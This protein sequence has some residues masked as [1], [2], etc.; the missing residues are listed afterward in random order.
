MRFQPWLG[1]IFVM[2]IIVALALLGR[3]EGWIQSPTSQ[4]IVTV[5]GDTIPAAVPP[6]VAAFL[7]EGRSWRAARLMRNVLARAMQPSA[8]MVLLAARAE[9]G[10][11]GWDRVIAYLEG[12]SWLDEVDGGEG[13][14]WLARALDE[15]GRPAD[16]VNAYDRYL[17][18][19]G[20]VGADR[21]AVARLRRALVLLRVDPSGSG[22]EA[23][24]EAR[25]TSSE[26]R[27]WID[28]LAAEALAPGGDT[29]AVAAAVSGLPDEAGLR[30][31]GD[32][33]LIDAFEAAG[34][35]VGALSAA[36]SARLRAGTAARRA[37]FASRAGRIADEIGE[38]ALAREELR[39]AIDASPGSASARDA[40]NL[41]IGYPGL[42]WE[43]R[44]A[45]ADV[46]DRH[47]N[48]TRAATTYREW[49]ANVDA[50]AAEREQVRYRLGATLLNGG[51]VSEGERILRE[52]YGASPSV[53]RRAMNLVGRGQFGRGEYT[54]AFETF[55]LLAERFPGSVEGSEGLFLVADYDHD[56]EAFGRAV[57]VY[58]EVANVFPGTDRAGLSMMRIGGIRF[59]EGDHAG[60][61]AIWNEYRTAYPTGQRWLEATYWAGRSA[62]EIG[63]VAGARALYEAVL[64]RDPL[65]YYAVRASERLGRT[66]WP[67][68]MAAS[69]PVEP[70]AVARAEQILRSVDLLR[71][72]G[73]HAEADAEAQRLAEN[74]SIGTAASYALAEALNDRGYSIRGIA[75][76]QRLERGGEPMSPRL[77]RILY[78]FPFRDLIAAEAREKGLDPFVVAALVRQESLFTPRISSPVGARGLMQV[79]PET[80]ASLARGVGIDGWNTDLLYNPEVNAHLGTIYLA[81]QM[82]TYDRS[83]P[84]VFSAYNAG[85]RRVEAWKAF[86]EYGDEELFTERIPFRET[87]DYVKIL[88]R[89]IE[90]YRGLYGSDAEP[91][92]RR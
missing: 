41:L 22:R 66:Y 26:I 32:R 14:F 5:E 31:R 37:E 83:L 70:E 55:R 45:I 33:A 13:W 77:L 9:A 27:E 67:V 61:A 18:R 30:F 65:S 56:R 34:D 24:A 12:A 90:I 2:L 76:G 63:D 60:A 79:M 52:L 42:T 29:A 35:P 19:V 48:R 64:G 85:P 91:A 86:P 87:R 38:R 73:L 23:L 6:K 11:G 69:P 39:L 74:Q 81:E 40:A 4:A 58:R 49:L 57:N 89:N 92:G 10:W 1:L 43:D 71:D 17:D 25:A 62:E 53:A 50:P 8:E 84:S 47:G 59:R 54:S 78:P 36:R 7:E 16:A 75:I 44:L 82:S 46:D 3:G 72:A 68:P 20:E 15:S 88:T 51:N 80:G 21:A 28:V